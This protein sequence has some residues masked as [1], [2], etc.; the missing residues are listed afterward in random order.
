MLAPDDRPVQPLV[1]HFLSLGRL[2]FV[3]VVVTIIRLQGRGG[4]YI[5]RLPESHPDHQ[6]TARPFLPS[7]DA[8]DEAQ[9]REE[10]GRGLGG[11]F[12]GVGPARLAE[13]CNWKRIYNV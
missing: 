4:F 13:L 6:G 2:T 5:Q 9:Q 10:A 1:S 11:E 3:S 12:R 7:P 8:R